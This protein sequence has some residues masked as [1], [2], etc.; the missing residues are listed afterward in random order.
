MSDDS[1]GGARRSIGGQ[2]IR[3]KVDPKM[4]QDFKDQQAR[5]NALQ[6]QYRARPGAGQTNYVM[7]TPMAFMPPIMMTRLIKNVTLRER[8]FKGLLGVALL[9]SLGCVSGFYDQEK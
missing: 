5:S 3:G 2:E 7:L 4:L 1:E 9:H 6:E 8:S